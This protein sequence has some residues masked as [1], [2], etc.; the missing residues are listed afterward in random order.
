MDIMEL[1]KSMVAHVAQL[2]SQLQD[3]QSVLEQ[4]KK[5]SYEQ[6]VLDGKNSMA[7]PDNA[8][9]YTKE[10][11]EAM[12]ANSTA[13]LSAKVSTLEAELETVKSDLATA[14]SDLATVQAD[15]DAKISAAVLAKQQEIIAKVADAQLDNALVI[16]EYTV[17]AQA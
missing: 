16:A 8:K 14:Q 4:L 5:Q 9:I 6:G 3:A 12:V 10:E 7:N 17:P 1:F 15:V 13:E 11:A 2:Q